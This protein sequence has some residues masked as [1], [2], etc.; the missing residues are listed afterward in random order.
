MCHFDEPRISIFPIGEDVSD[1][2]RWRKGTAFYFKNKEFQLEEKK[3]SEVLTESV[4]KWR[5]T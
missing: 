2:L 1:S 5:H 3:R 4:G